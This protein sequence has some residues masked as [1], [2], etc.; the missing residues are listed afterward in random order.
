MKERIK[1]L[2][3]A[4]NISG[5]EFSKS[6]GQSESW[7]RTI[8]KT[9]GND[10]VAKIL[11]TYPNVSIHWLVL[12]EGEIFKDDNPLLG[13][14]NKNYESILEDLRSDN[15]EL[16]RENQMLRESILEMMER[17]EKLMVENVTLRAKELQLT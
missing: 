11:T 13:M 3:Q 4:L 15:K 10:I 6:I 17:N 9:I 7:S 16:R 8:G 12:G 5:R 14:F 1:S 2:I